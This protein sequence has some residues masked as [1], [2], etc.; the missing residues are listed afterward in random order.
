MHQRTGQGVSAECCCDAECP[1][2]EE[3][4][5]PSIGVVSRAAPLS[6]V[7]RV[8]L[9]QVE[10]PFSPFVGQRLVELSANLGWEIDSNEAAPSGDHGLQRG[11]LLPKPKARMDTYQVNRSVFNFAAT[12][13]DMTLK[14]CKL[15]QGAQVR[16]ITAELSSAV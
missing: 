11:K 4:A 13:I 1:L 15:S 5:L 8:E 14:V 3:V 6:A 12:N 16:L 7:Q 9:P 2:S 10:V